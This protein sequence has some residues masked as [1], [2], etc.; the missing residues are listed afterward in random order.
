MATIKNFRDT[1][2]EVTDAVIEQLEKGTIVWRCS[3]NEAGFPTNA[4][5]GISYRGWN[6]F[7]L[8][9]H[10][11]LKGYQSPRYITFKQAQ[12]LGG[13]IKK[14]EHGVKITYWA[15]IKIRQQDADYGASGNSEETKPQTRMVPKVYTVFNIDQTEGITFPELV[16]SS[17]TTI[18]K[19][20]ACEQV[21][22]QMPDRPKLNLH[23]NYPVYYPALDEVAVPDIKQ[24][25]CSEE[26]YCA[27]FHE[28]AHS[29][30]HQ[31]RLN[32]K[33]IAQPSTYGSD[34]YSREEL[35]AELTATFLCAITGIQQQT[36]ENSAAYLQGWLKALKNDKTLLLKAAG[37]AQKAADYIL[38]VVYQLEEVS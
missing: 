34:L 18:E 1:Y 13:T 26:Y 8:N 24:F 25:D 22:E 20:E 4:T 30:G 15:S 5:T 31:R 37:Q 14:G 3:W 2:Q 17:S 36:L 32:R 16:R 19:I 33:E 11:M 28:L 10:T 38:S 23:G 27:L 6:V 29:T 21:V 12:H 35:T 9:F 7:W